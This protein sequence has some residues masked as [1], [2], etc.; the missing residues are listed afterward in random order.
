MGAY[1][2]PAVPNYEAKMGLRQMWDLVR[3]MDVMGGTLIYRSSPPVVSEPHHLR[4]ESLT[5][6][7]APQPLAFFTHSTTRTLPWTV[8]APFA[9]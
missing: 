1:V 3:V 9:L 2:P 4:V 7:N 5:T 8:I 6:S